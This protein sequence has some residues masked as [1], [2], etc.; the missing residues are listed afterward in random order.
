MPP[1]VD[2]ILG[3]VLVSVVSGRIIGG[4]L[5]RLKSSS[6]EVDNLWLK[7]AEPTRLREAA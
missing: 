1:L 7:P 6:D 2:L 5:R 4:C 3:W